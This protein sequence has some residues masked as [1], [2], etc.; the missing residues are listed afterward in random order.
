MIIR[1]HSSYHGNRIVM[2]V[3]CSQAWTQP[4]ARVLLQNQLWPFAHRSP[5]FR[6]LPLPPSPSASASTA[7]ATR[8]QAKNLFSLQRPASSKCPQLGES[9][10]QQPLRNLNLHG[11][12]DCNFCMVLRVQ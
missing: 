1:S 12:R 11:F 4:Q 2:N 7:T 6:M 8:A 3:A 5:R 9:H 10:R